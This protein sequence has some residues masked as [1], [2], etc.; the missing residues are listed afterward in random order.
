MR[1][2]RLALPLLP[3][4]YLAASAVV[5]RLV[6]LHG[7]EALVYFPA[8][9]LAA[10]ARLD[11]RAYWLVPTLVSAAVICGTNWGE[12]PSSAGATRLL[13]M[14]AMW[15]TACIGRCA[16]PD[17][18]LRSH[19]DAQLEIL[20]REN[21]ALQQ[22]SDTCNLELAAA[23][24]ETRTR[25]DVAEQKLHDSESLYQSLV[26]HLPLS[27]IRKD[28][29]FRYTFANR[30]FFEFLGKDA[31]QVL[32]KTDFELFPEEFAKKYRSGDEEVVGAGGLYDDIEEFHTADG[33]VRFIQVLKAP[34]LDA[35]QAIVGV[36]VMLWDITDRRRAEQ[37]LEISTRELASRNAAL[38]QSE[39][40]L[41]Q[42]RGIFESVLHSIADAVVV[43]DERGRFLVW[44][45]AATRIMGMGPTDNSSDEWS[46]V[47]GI[48]EPDR[49]TP[50]PAER[51]PLACAM[52]G[53][54]ARGVEVYVRN[55]KKPA[56]AYLS[57]SGTPLRGSTGSVRGGVVV[58]RDVTSEKAAE[59]ELCSKNQDLETLLYVISHDL[60][61][62]LRAIE[63][64][65][66]LV[67][68]RY[69][70]RLDDK[71]RDFLQRVVNGAERLDRLLEDVLT[72]SRVQRTSQAEG[73]IDSGEIVDDVLK[74][75]E[76]RI[77]ETQ[78]TVQVAS[79][80]P[81][82]RADRRWATQAVQNLVSNALKYTNDKE[83]PDVEIA[84]YG[85]MAL[86]LA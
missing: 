1:A 56:G 11:R 48:F 37:S 47:Y 26:D 85:G 67:Y 33:Q 60:R 40:K 24:A 23:L 10:W 55:S 84:G 68:E 34:V 14:A 79:A 17:E 2:F 49:V 28:A 54:E 63:N 80:L 46:R 64:F 12:E 4:V 71:G 30:K 13:A 3:F 41:R 73:V 58:F 39:E 76:P 86:G 42:Q 45:P 15:E 70:G 32:G 57:V 38:E 52:R 25:K 18:R 66:K 21:T 69:A 8:I 74:R 31:G 36:Q 9:W 53:E 22:Q 29:G 81:D 51:L 5:E 16:R 50:F 72:L 35:H 7:G 61:E 65:S 77:R 82:I 19:F 27:L 20:R 83:P 44:N 43:A 59:A 78:A 6:D 62:P 75:L